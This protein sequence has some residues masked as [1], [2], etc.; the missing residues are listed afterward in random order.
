[1]STARA[2]G[3]NMPAAYGLVPSAEYFNHVSTPVVT[4]V[5]DIL[6]PWMSKEIKNYGQTIGN[7]IKEQGFVTGFEGR[8]NPTRATDTLQPI[9][10]NSVLLYQAETLHNAIDA[11][12]VPS[13]IRLIQIAGWG[14]DTLSGFQYS[15]NIACPSVTDSGCT[16]NYILDEKPIFTSDGDKTVVTPSALAMGGEKWW[17][18]INQYN[19]G[20]IFGF[21]HKDIMEIS[22]LLDFISNTIKNA[23][24]TSSVYLSTTTPTDTSNRLRLSVHSPV[25]IGAYDAQGDFTGKTC[26]VS[27]ICV[28]QENIPNSSYYEF[29]EGKYVNLPQDQLQ[30]VTLQGTDT[31]TF[32][33][34]Y[35]KVAP[36]GQ[37]TTVSFTDIPVTT[38]TQA[39]IDVNT[40][41]GNP[42]LKLDVT[43]NG[44]TDFILA[45]NTTFDPI[46]YLQI[47]KA[48][49][50]S[51][52]IV[53]AKKDA[54]D[55]RIA[56]IITSI[57]KGKIDKAKLKVDKF[58]SVL[59]NKLSKPD[60]KKPRPKKLSK[61]DAQLLLDLLNGL[62][63]NLG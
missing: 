41:T 31:G 34:E 54:F 48:T 16:G 10:G 37:A 42:Q 40:T 29:G 9:K 25:S 62:L 43:G 33:F 2:L 11:L 15:S 13:T 58:K 45:P 8:N 18:N 39:V 4:F 21:D 28:V 36:S 6:D 7:Y 60:P 27:G 47:M 23:S 57:Q 35:Q 55:K 19:K 1:V 56:S 50:D 38:Q 26:D 46:S 44:T 52:D 49:V 24:T 12:T 17:V 14:I 22:P 5:P 59:E 61:T 53:Q 30:K 32:T 51:L 20:P 3:Q 63:D